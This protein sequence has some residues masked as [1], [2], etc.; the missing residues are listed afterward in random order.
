M[1]P[2]CSF[3][4]R[5]DGEGSGKAECIPCEDNMETK[6]ENEMDKEV[7]CL[8]EHLPLNSPAKVRFLVQLF[9]LHLYCTLYVIL[10]YFCFHR[11]DLCAVLRSTTPMEWFVLP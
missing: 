7:L 2:E 3:L 9:E 4:S 11:N 6:A 1:P 10:V 8:H 5:F